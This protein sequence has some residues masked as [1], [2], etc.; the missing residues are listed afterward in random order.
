MYA[1]TD[2]GSGCYCTLLQYLHSDGG[3]QYRDRFQ[4]PAPLECGQPAP[5]PRLLQLRYTHPVFPGPAHHVPAML[6][7]RQIVQQAGLGGRVFAQAAKEPCKNIDSDTEYT[8]LEFFL[9]KKKTL[10]MFL[11]GCSMCSGRLT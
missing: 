2:I 3:M 6:R 9:E 7:V 11:Y 5:L 8:S 10:L 4:L 1:K